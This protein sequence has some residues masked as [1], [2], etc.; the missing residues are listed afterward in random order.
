MQLAEHNRVQLISVPGH[1]VLLEMK[2]QISWQERD[3]N[4]RS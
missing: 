2:R 4:I 1:G 3:L